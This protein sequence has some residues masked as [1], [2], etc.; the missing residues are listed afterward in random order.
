MP[1]II[2]HDAKRR[3]IAQTAI[4]VFVRDGI[5]E[6]HLGTVAALCSFGRTTMYQYFRNIDEVLAFSLEEIF[7][8]LMKDIESVAE[9]PGN[10]AT[11]K[12]LDLLFFLEKVAVEDKER[13]ILVLDFLLHPKRIIP[14]MSFDVSGKVRELRASVERLLEAGVKS[15]ELKQVS[16][17]SMGFTLFSLVEAAAIH[18]VLYDNISLEETVASTKVLIE[19]LRA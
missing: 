14:G 4:S 5:R 10:S 13:M 1:K 6:A 18:S 12:L 7:S 19:G 17:K 11:E 15:G 9:K 8:R 2:D 16:A 3:E